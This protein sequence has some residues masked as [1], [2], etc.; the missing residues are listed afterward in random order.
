MEELREYHRAY[1]RRAPAAYLKH[2]FDV[3]FLMPLQEQTS[4]LLRSRLGANSA[5]FRGGK[6]VLGVAHQVLKVAR[7]SRPGHE[8]G[9]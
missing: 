7:P 4:S 9:I 2:R 1:F 8:S 5:A 3:G 6:G